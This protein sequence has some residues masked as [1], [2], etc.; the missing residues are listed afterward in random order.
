MTTNTKNKMI[1]DGTIQDPMPGDVVGYSRCG[2]TVDVV[3]ITRKGVKRGRMVGGIRY[4]LAPFVRTGKAYGF[5]VV[6]V[7]FREPSRSYTSEEIHAAVSAFVGTEAKVEDRK[8]EIASRRR[9]AL[10]KFN[11]EVGDHVLVNY[12][13]GQVWEKVG[14]VN[15]QTGKIGIEKRGAK[16]FNARRSGGGRIGADVAFLFGVKQRQMREVRWIT[17]SSVREV[18]KA[19]GV[20]S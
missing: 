2:C 6:G 4:E 10:G 18:R 16:A 1:M 15:E 5:T 9:D 20:A 19:N 13:D 3:V 12:T 8:E 17:A 14:A 7:A 11:V